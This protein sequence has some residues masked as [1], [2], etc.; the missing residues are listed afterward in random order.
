MIYVLY[1]EDDFSKR[2][3]LEG[4]RREIGTPELLEANTTTLAGSGLSL[5][6]LQEVCSVVPFLA[7]RRL[8]IVERLLGQFD[9]TRADRRQMRSP[10]GKGPLEE[11]QGL[12][13]ALSQVPTSTTLVFV[14]GSL[15]LDNELLLKARSAAEVH[16]FLPPRGEALGGWIRQRVAA[17][18]ATISQ[19]AVRR[20]ADLVGGNLWVVSSEVE[21]LALYAGEDGIDEEAVTVLV[22]QTQEANVFRAVD[23]ILEGRSSSAMPIILRLRQSGAEVSYVISM[24]ARQ[25]RLILLAYELLPQ[26]LPRPELGRRLGVTAEFAI[27][28]TEEQARLHAPERLVAMYRRLLET[29]L[30]IKRG[31]LGEDLALETL[32]AELSQGPSERVSPPTHG[33][34]R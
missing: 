19:G 15:R 28:R 14:E 30:A 21:K 3:F 9:G 16:E 7:E 1:G 32:V 12:A 4:L 11:W 25:V 24:L 5:R 20:L 23:A 33:G 34:S 29:D 13:E 6:H 2:E 26:R 18:G 31:E 8:I 22:A 17:A 10:P 27:R